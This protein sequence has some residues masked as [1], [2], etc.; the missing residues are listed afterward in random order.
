MFIIIDISVKV[1]NKNKLNHCL[2]AYET[3]TI[4]MKMEL[5]K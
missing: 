5:T 3:V 1:V 4:M 2:K